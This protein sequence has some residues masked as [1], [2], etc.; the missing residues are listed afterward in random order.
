MEHM[1]ELTAPRLPKL[2]KPEAVNFSKLATLS[3]LGLDQLPFGTITVDF[4]GAVLFY[5]EWQS[6][7]TGIPRYLVLNRNFFGEIAPC[8]RVAAFEGRFRQY[9]SEFKLT[10]NFSRLEMFDY[11]FTFKEFEYVKIVF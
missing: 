9:V 10:P 1:E 4:D 2:L 8:T 3:D 5:N 11:I 7:F 6:R